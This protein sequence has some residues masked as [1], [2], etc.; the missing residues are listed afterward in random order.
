MFVCVQ[1]QYSL[2][3]NFT[4]KSTHTGHEH[5][6]LRYYSRHTVHITANNWT[7]DKKQHYTVL[8]L[9]NL[10]LFY[11]LN[12]LTGTNLLSWN[13]LLSDGPHGLYAVQYNNSRK[14]SCVD[15]GG[16]AW[17]KMSW[18][19]EETCRKW[20]STTNLLCYIEN[21]IELIPPDW[22]CG[23]PSLLSVGTGVS[24]P[25]VKRRGVTTLLHLLSSSRMV[26]LYLHSHIRHLDTM[27]N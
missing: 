3:C 10:K 1:F 18:I 16:P 21:C 26:V 25:G 9:Y 8:F 15:D 17:P 11:R 6:Q 13:K 12:L 19:Y 4:A 5:T 2:Q 27:L 22:P 14:V 20:H 23:P 7:Q 24:F